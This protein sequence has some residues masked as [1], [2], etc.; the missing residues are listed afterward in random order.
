M[1]IAVPDYRSDNYIFDVNN[2]PL[3]ETNTIAWMRFMENVNLIRVRRTQVR[4]VDIYTHFM[5]VRVVRLNKDCFFRTCLNGG[6]FHYRLDY[7]TT[8]QEAEKGHARWVARV[9]KSQNT[10]TVS[11]RMSDKD[12]DKEIP[13]TAA[14]LR[15]LIL[16]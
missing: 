14:H 9:I 15:K 3:R 7:H 13:L 2:V 12:R 4:S 6:G 11:D 8:W 5:G 16:K 1:T 10:V